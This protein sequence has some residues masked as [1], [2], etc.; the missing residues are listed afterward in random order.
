[1]SKEPVVAI[2]SLNTEQRK[3]VKRVVGLITDSMVRVS[4]EKEFQNDELTALHQKF[5]VDKKIVRRMAKSKFKQSF[6]EDCAADEEFHD[7]YS[8]VLGVSE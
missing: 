1:M 5:S 7:A 2:A 4:A 6:E 3:E 8:L